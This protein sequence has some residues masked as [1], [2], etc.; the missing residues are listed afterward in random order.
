MDEKNFP[1]IEIETDV[2][3]VNYDELLDKFESSTK[4]T[5]PPKK[6]K[7][8]LAFA[9][10]LSAVAIFVGIVIALVN[11]NPESEEEEI[12][13]EALIT[14]KVDNNKVW[15]SKIKTNKKGKIKQ[16]G[17]GMLLN[18]V[19]NK[20]ESIKIKN[21]HDTFTLTSFTPT[22]TTKEGDEETSATQYTLVGYEEFEFQS[23]APDDLANDCSGLVF[24]KIISVDASKNLKDYG[25]DK[26]RAIANVTYA[27]KKKSII[28]VGKDALDDSGTYISFGNSNAVYLV[29]KDAVDSLIKDK[30]SLI[31]LTINENVEDGESV[32]F[33]YLT[34]SGKAYEKDITLTYNM[35]TL[36]NESTYVITKP[37]EIYADN[38]EA[39]TISGNARGLT[40]TKIVCLNPTEKDIK[41]Y[42]LADNYAHLI[43]KYVDITVDLVASKPDK[44]DNCYI[45][46]NKGNI[47]Y[48]IASSSISWVGTDF[49]K[50]SSDYVLNPNMEGLVKMTVTADKTTEFTFNTVTTPTT[51]ENGNTTDSTTTTIESFGKEITLGYFENYFNN[52]TLLEKSSKKI[53]KPEGKPTLVIT[54]E[55]MQPGKK[56]VVEFYKADNSKYIAT[57]N[58][59]PVGYVYSTY[60]TKIIKQT[61]TIAKNKDVESFKAETSYDQQQTS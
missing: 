26:P 52:V 25:L 32:Q 42:G 41:K 57:V 6:P 61:T 34:L 28:K 16:N 38:D 10:T 45:M 30:E 13:E 35:D 12:V 31:S 20:I 22:K 17:S 2:D 55:Y 8:K 47:I 40:A 59:R 54:Y 23:G 27:D 51:D 18:Y 5:R 9:L 4:A 19:P 3:E 24:S 58:S 1:E 49:D 44:D 7:R 29:A 43:A 33:D 46:K 48:Q 21:E 53:E 37:Y 50:L 15:Q 14:T 60:I 36:S 39:S 56:D 11:Y